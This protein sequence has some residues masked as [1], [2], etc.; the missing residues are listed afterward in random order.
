[1]F[2]I[3]LNICR[4]R[5]PL[6]S[7]TLARPTQSLIVVLRFSGQHIARTH[8]QPKALKLK[9]LVGERLFGFMLGPV[10][11][12]NPLSN[13]HVKCHFGGFPRNVSL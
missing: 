11:A 10:G 2:F 1:M 5:F 6:A 7:R 9:M 3:I 4:G 13:F 12:W 8:F